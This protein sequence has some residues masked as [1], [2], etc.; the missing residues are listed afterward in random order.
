MLYSERTGCK[1]NAD[2]L[3]VETRK[4][5]GS[6]SEQGVAGEVREGKDFGIPCRGAIYL[7]AFPQRPPCDEVITP[8]ADAF[9]ALF[10]RG[11]NIFVI[12]GHCGSNAKVLFAARRLE[13]YKSLQK[14][15]WIV[16]MSHISILAREQRVWNEIHIGSWTSNT[17]YHSP[18]FVP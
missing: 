15:K 5:C 18:L 17:L 11:N 6:G 12:F 10:S 7:C 1:L 2:F 8:S 9:L 14:L 16:F 3:C 4:W 13:F